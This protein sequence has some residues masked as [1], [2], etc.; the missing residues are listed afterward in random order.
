M[1]SLNIVLEGHVVQTKSDG[2][3]QIIRADEI[4]GESHLP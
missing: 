2:S 4:I 3:T 1:D